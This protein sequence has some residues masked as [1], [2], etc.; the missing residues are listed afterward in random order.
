VVVD[1]SESSWQAA[2]AIGSEIHGVTH[3]HDSPSIDGV[4]I[5][6]ALP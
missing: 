6:L 3:M 1:R 2:P 4:D 5:E